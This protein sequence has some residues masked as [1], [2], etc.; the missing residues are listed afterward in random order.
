MNGRDKQVAKIF[1]TIR[2]NLDRLIETL[3][4]LGYVFDVK[5]RPESIDWP[6]E[7]RLNH[8]IA[9]AQKRQRKGGK[10]PLAV[11]DDPALQWV[12]DERIVLPSRFF[13]H[14][15]APSIRSIDPDTPRELERLEKLAGGPIP[16]TVRAW[17]LTCGAV[18][19]RGRHPF[20]NRQGKIEALHT[21]P[22]RECVD[23]FAGGWLP[24]SPTW[25]LRLPEP[26]LDAHLED[27]RVFLDALRDAFQWAGMPGLANAAVKPERELAYVRSRMEAF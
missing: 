6:L 25:K 16:E 18:D 9:Y 2:G 14:P 20:L 15:Q 7:V 10:S 5:A 24:L 8:A 4:E 3:T 19:L 11:F 1:E 12:R 27:G 26:G 22:V 13:P 21:A 23:R 17:F